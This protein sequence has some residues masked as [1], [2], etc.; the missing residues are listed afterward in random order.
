MLGCLKHNS[1]EL[2]KTNIYSW[3]MLYNAT[4]Y[5][6][7]S[8]MTALEEENVQL[9]YAGQCHNLPRKVLND[10]PRRRKNVQLVYAGQCHDL[11]R[12]VLNDRRI[13]RKNVQ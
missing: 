9:V 4:T 11:P 5:P 13:R 6:E 8:L 7:N 10:R 12:K 2:S 1:F 3:F